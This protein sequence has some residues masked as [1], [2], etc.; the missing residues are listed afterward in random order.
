MHVFVFQLSV[1]NQELME[2]SLTRQERLQGEGP[3]G[4]RGLLPV[5]ARLTQRLYGEMAACLC[6]LRSLCNVL[7]QRAQGH[8]PNLSMLLGIACKCALCCI[9][10]IEKT[11]TP[12]D[13]A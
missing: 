6:D 7:T 10:A 5:G 3:Q 1:Q 13:N 11:R 4:G 12:S 8:D 9:H 2:H